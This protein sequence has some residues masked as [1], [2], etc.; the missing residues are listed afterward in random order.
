M[1]NRNAVITIRQNGGE[2]NIAFICP[3]IENKHTKGAQT[4]T[5]QRKITPNEERMLFLKQTHFIVN[6]DIH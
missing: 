4:W 5:P 3:T 6:Y 1:N 2:A